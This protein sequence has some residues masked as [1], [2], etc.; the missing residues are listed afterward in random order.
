MLQ[1]Q[2]Y[3]KKFWQEKQNYLVRLTQG[4]CPPQENSRVKN[5]LYHPLFVS[6]AHIPNLG[7]LGPRI[8]PLDVCPG[9]WVWVGVVVNCDYIA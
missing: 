9:G 4:G 6:K 1:K 3:F 2:F 7:P 8:V 5:L